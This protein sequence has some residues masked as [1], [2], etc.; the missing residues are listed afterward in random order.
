MRCWIGSL[1]IPLL[2]IQTA[3]STRFHKI[4]NHIKSAQDKAF[5]NA[6]LKQL[7][8]SRSNVSIPTKLGSFPKEDTVVSNVDL[9]LGVV[10]AATNSTGSYADGS[11]ASFQIYTEDSLP[12]SPAPSS[13]CATA[14][15]ATVECNSTVPLMRFAVLE[16]EN[17]SPLTI[18]II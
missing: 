10:D 18:V 15:T 8:G 9:S 6:L 2:F 1:F 4:I 16:R 14:L 12:T 3:S 5:H 17:H 11:T 13:A 7:A